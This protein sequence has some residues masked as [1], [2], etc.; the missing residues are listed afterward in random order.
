MTRI[1]A[2]DDDPELL[3]VLQTKLTA[4]GYEVETEPDPIK[5]LQRVEAEVP[6]L[7]ILDIRMPIL[8]GREFCI[9]A[10][11]SGFENPIIFLTAMGDI[12]SRIN[13][14]R[15]G[16]T[17]FLAKPFDPRLLVERIE[18]ALRSRVTSDSGNRP[19]LIGNLE[20][21]S[22]P[23]ILEVARLIAERSRTVIETSTEELGSIWM[24][25]RLIVDAE[26]SGKRGRPAL[27]D[28]LK[29]DAGV[30]RVYEES[31]ATT[32]PLNLQVSDL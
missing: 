7:L 21:E 24:E 23:G 28:L 30:F 9:A 2:V 5:G 13:A 17:G 27:D 10:R 20:H 25:R 15:V 8:E 1:L 18:H 29:V 19:V 31:H 4:A 3:A 14:Y 11:D 16:A 32:N 6:D 22:V 26:F 12:D